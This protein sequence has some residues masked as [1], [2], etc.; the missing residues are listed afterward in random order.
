[1]SDS[2]VVILEFTDPEGRVWHA[3]AMLTRLRLAKADPGLD[4]SKHLV[5][6]DGMRISRIRVLPPGE[7]SH[8]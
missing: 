2:Q 7:G 3:G 8:G 4:E 5:A 6:S 1:M